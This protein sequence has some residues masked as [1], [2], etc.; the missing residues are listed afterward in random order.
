MVDNSGESE[1]VGGYVREGMEWGVVF[2]CTVLLDVW[3]R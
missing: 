3:D 1:G 2:G